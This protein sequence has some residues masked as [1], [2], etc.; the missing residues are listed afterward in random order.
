MC[1]EVAFGLLTTK[2]RIFQRKLSYKTKKNTKII[3]VVAKLHNFCIR[4]TQKDGAG[5]VGTISGSG[6]SA[7]SYGT[8]P[9]SRDDGLGFNPG[10]WKRSPSSCHCW[11]STNRLLPMRPVVMAF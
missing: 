6:Y 3:C 2:W 10:S 11:T 8:E 4:M 1:I 9:L 7:K 5:R